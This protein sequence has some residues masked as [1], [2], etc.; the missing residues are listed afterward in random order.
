MDEKKA[1]SLRI[2]AL[3]TIRNKHSGSDAETQTKRFL[4]A[5]QSLGS[6]S[7]LEAYRYLDIL[8]PP[9]RKRD[10]IKLGYV[11]DLVWVYE[12]SLCGP[13]HRVGRYVYGGKAS[14]PLF[15][16]LLDGFPA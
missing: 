7:T 13:I 2:E 14:Y 10:L 6:I 1:P 8:H 11:I 12:P 3:Q 9:A 5:A 16:G 4:E 15:D